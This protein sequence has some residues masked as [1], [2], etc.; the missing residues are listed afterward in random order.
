MVNIEDG[1]SDKTSLTMFH[2]STF[3]IGVTFGI[4]V[5]YRLTLTSL[6]LAPLVILSLLGLG[7]VSY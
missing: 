1:I 4:V 2:L 5:N 3:L 6:C 7:V